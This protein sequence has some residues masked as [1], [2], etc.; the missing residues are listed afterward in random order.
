[1]CV[2][3]AV[4]HA[5]KRCVDSNK[6]CVCVCLFMCV[7]NVCVPVCLCLFM[8]IICMRVFVFYMCVYTVCVRIV[9]MPG[10]PKAVFIYVCHII[11]YIYIYIYISSG[12]GIAWKK[13]VVVYAHVQ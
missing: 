1:M 12:D 2:C 3:V 9:A 13:F 6:W 11:L 10:N 4:L 7:Y 8:P 5:N